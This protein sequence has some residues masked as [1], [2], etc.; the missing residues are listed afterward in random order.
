[1][2]LLKQFDLFGQ[3]LT[4]EENNSNLFKTRTGNL[5]SYILIACIMTACFIFGQ[6]IYKRETPL[7]VTGV[8]IVGRKESTVQLNDFP[9]LIS[10]V[11]KDSG[12]IYNDYRELLNVEVWYM[13]TTPEG[14]VSREVYYGFSE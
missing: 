11:R 10:L 5:L 1:M 12:P 4:F 14:V 8:E 7:I 2:K 6:E 3:L 9:F 13:N